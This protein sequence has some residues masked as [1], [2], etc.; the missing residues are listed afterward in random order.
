MPPQD[1]TNQD[2][3][4]PYTERWAAESPFIGE[5]AEEQQTPV[6]HPWYEAY[7]PFREEQELEEMYE[8][9]AEEEDY[10]AELED[11]EPDEEAYEPTD[12]ASEWHWEYT[13]GIDRQAL[14]NEEAREEVPRE[15]F[16]DEEEE[17]AAEEFLDELYDQQ[18]ASVTD[19]TFPS[20]ESL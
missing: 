18:V 8:Q 9:E 12:E 2:S 17:L 19:V 13:E 6:I 5:A 10:S 3:V 4:Q 11:E 7:T 14:L 1:D 15:F 20:G 16:V